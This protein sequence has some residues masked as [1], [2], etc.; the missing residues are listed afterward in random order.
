LQYIIELEELVEPF[1]YIINLALVSP[2]DLAKA[3]AMF[4]KLRLPVRLKTFKSGLVVVM[5][6]SSTEEVIERN[7]LRFMEEGGKGVTALDVGGRFNWSVG[8]AMELLLV[9]SG[10]DRA[11][12]RWRRRK[13]FCVEM[14]QLKEYGFGRI[15]F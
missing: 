7:L 9:F 10:F 6:A 3:C 12:G 13:E 4:P 5:E 2:T 8:V 15:D 1:C 11:D 14:L